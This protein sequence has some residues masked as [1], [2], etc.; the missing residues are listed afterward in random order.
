MA[1][2]HSQISSL[3]GPVSTDGV[4]DYDNASYRLWSRQVGLSVD[5]LRAA[6]ESVHRFARDDDRLA[7]GRHAIEPVVKPPRG[8]AKPATPEQ[9]K[10]HFAFVGSPR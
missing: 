1:A 8:A 4:R 6:V 5:E 2:A 10:C 9:S 7:H 3:P